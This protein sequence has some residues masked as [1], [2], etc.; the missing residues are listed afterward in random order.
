MIRWSGDVNS[1]KLERDSV[2]YHTNTLALVT[3]KIA[4]HSVSL[5]INIIMPASLLVLAVLTK[6]RGICLI[7]C[8][9]YRFRVR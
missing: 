2:H 6:D 4:R 3:N 7:F 5:S 8:Q 1:H 9:K